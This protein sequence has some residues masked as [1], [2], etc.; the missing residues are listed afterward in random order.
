MRNKLTFGFGTSA[1]D[2]VGPPGGLELNRQEAS[3]AVTPGLVLVGQRQL[4]ASRGELTANAER[5]E[6]VELGDPVA[7][8]VP[9]APTV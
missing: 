1:R 8:V 5:A 7:V 6:G 2:W 9:A 3:F 4:G